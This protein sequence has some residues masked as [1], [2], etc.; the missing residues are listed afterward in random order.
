MTDAIERVVRKQEDMY[1]QGFFKFLNR[2]EIELR[3][4]LVQLEERFAQ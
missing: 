4:V 2:K 1:T 3:D